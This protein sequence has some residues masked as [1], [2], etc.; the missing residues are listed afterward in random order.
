MF[1]KWEFAIVIKD[2][3]LVLETFV[4]QSANHFVQTN[5]ITFNV[6]GVYFMVVKRF[7]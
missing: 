3:P 1:F 2:D 4:S 7:A 5:K 6:H